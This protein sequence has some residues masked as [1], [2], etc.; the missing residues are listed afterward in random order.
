[1]SGVV[2]NDRFT[3]LNYGVRNTPSTDNGIAAVNWNGMMYFNWLFSTMRLYS[4]TVDDVG[5][6]FRSNSLPFGRDG[7]DAAYAPYVSWLFVANDAGSSGTSSVLVYD[8]LNWHEMMRGFA[9]KR[10]RDV[11]IQTVSGGRNRLWIDHGGDSIYIEMP[12][13]KGNPL[14][15]TGMSYMHES[16]VESAIID[17]G[18]A[19]K[20]PKY[21]KELTVTADN[22]DG[23]GKRIELD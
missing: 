17:M 18:T 21:I 13:L 16:V 14:D 19:S 8:G 11:F 6:G 20:L 2:D 9:N 22:L 10:I 3:E 12:Y 15:D 23:Y 1:M 4:G 7:V 5:Q